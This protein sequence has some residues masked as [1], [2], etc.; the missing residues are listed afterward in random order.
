[1]GHVIVNGGGL[2]V[3]E[4]G[5]RG[6]PA[7]VFVNSLGTDSRVW[8]GVVERLPSA[9]NLLRMDKRGHGLSALE[10]SAR[11][12]EAHAADLAGV[13]DA[14]A[15]RRALVVGLSIGGMIAQMLAVTRPDCV[16]GLLL[17]DTAHRIGTPESW[18][19]RIDSVRAGGMAFIA[20]AVMERWFSTAF[21]R[22]RADVV[23]AWRVLFSRTPPEGY[24][25]AC[26]AVRD[27]D[28]TSLGPRIAVPTRFAVGAEDAA[29][30]PDLVHS[31]AERVPDALFGLIE[32][33]G[34]LTPVEQPDAV[35]ALVRAQLGE[36]DRA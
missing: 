15:V 33:A 13:L 25:A 4:Q 27:A 1:M 31:A 18:N 23:E 19:A 10:P 8:D 28:L 21:R 34:H 20:D 36:V 17:L 2:N 16:G 26:E 32:G 12:V 6:G 5:E 30:P 9:L 11:T 35:A 7:V 22:D 14:L 3:L 24:I 29:T